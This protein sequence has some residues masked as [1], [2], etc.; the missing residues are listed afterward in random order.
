MKAACLNLD[1]PAFFTKW[2]IDLC[3]RFATDD[4]GFGDVAPHISIVGFGNTGWADSG[5]VCNWQDVQA[6]TGTRGWCNCIT[7]LVR[8]MN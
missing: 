7:A 3:V 4:G 6:S 2:L 1:S 5:I 8:Y